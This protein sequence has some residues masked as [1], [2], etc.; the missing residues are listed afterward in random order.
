MLEL[1]KKAV[2]GSYKKAHCDQPV[3]VVLE[4][5]VPPVGHE[6]AEA[7]AGHVQDALGHHE[8]DGK[9]E[10]RSRKKREHQERQTLKQIRRTSTELKAL[11]L[12]FL[13]PL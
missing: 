7:H 12:A 10:V 8:A 3:C 6:E 11:L 13:K 4:Q 9:E 2:Q 1:P 5:R